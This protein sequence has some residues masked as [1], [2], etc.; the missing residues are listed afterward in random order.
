MFGSLDESLI[1]KNIS[2]VPSITQLLHNA[3]HYFHVPLSPFGVVGYTLKQSTKLQPE[4][5]FKKLLEPT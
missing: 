3:S 1:L 4:I 5:I 2:A